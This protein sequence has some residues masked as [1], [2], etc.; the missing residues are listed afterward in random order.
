MNKKYIELFLGNFKKCPD[1]STDLSIKTYK[2]LIA[3][4]AYCEKHGTIDS[5]VI[6]TFYA[7]KYPDNL[8]DQ[9]K[10]GNPFTC[11]ICKLRLFYTESADGISFINSREHLMY[12]ESIYCHVHGAFTH[13]YAPPEQ[14]QKNL[15]IKK[16]SLVGVT[17]KTLDQ[18]KFGIPIFCNSCKTKLEYVE[19]NQGRIPGVHC[20]EHG[21]LFAE[22]FTE[23]EILNF[24]SK[25]I[26][27]Y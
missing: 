25:F 6:L 9:L 19:F 18:V 2:H 22:E 4:Y 21:I 13:R 14:L 16:K 27:I 3:S 8:Y 23:E 11:A 24:V 20:P 5:N 17:E 15:E 26:Y 10:E 1:C 12:P 7:P